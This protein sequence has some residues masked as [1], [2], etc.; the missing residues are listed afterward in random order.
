MDTAI[1]NHRVPKLELF[2][3]QRQ[4]VEQLK[5]GSILLGGVGSGKSLTALFY[6]Y[7]KVTDFMKKPRD[8]YVITTAKKRDSS[9]WIREAAKMGISEI[10]NYS[11]G[12]IQLV[13]DSW[14]NIAK[15][16]AI[17]NAFFIFDEQKVSGYGMWANSMLKI[18]A[19]NPWILLTAT[20]GDIWMDYVT[21]FIA[22]GFYKNKTDFIRQHVVQNPYVKY[23]SVQRYVG[24]QRLE[25]YRR[26]IT[27]V[28]PYQKR[29]ER[30]T[31][32]IKVEYNQDLTMMACKD[33]WDGLENKPIRDANH[34]CH[35]LRKICNSDISRLVEL[36]KVFQEHGRLIVFYNFNYEL[37]ILR[38]FAKENYILYSEWNG[39]NHQDIPQ[40]DRWLY[41]VQYQAGA[42]A[43]ECIRTNA[44]LFYS[45]NYSYK[46]MEQSAGRI[47]RINTPYPDLFYYVLYSDSIIDKS[48]LKKLKKKENFNEKSL[49]EKFKNGEIN[50][51]KL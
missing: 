41:F 50:Y 44:I 37:E 21:V 20:P 34:L 48:I 40:E 14:N 39:H 16:V 17:Q 3:H 4:A 43:W 8:L 19:H 42:E 35:L 31:E 10:R 9:E 13:V 33:R 7:E 26:S 11:I 30:H 18:A 32:M 51:Y 47:D 12:N 24:T 25:R 46:Q 38:S 15:Y 1:S 2:P 29:T 49:F 6:F 22:N 5:T 28:M 45:L 27:V 36:K 23:F